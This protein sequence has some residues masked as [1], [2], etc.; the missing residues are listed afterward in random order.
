MNTFEIDLLALQPSQLYVC[1]EKLDAVLR[2][3]E[4]EGFPLK[5]IPIKQR[6][7]GLVMADGHSRALAAYRQGL[8]SVQAVWETDD[9][10]WEAY[11]ACVAWCR[12]AGIGSVADLEGRVVPAEEFESLWLDRCR[13]LHV[14]IARR[15]GK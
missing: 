4:A 11:D 13:V 10:D 12:E 8:R 6:A 9:L 5:P 2:V 14:D 3:I 7:C 15:R 1:Q